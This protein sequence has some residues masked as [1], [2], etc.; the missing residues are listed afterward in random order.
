MFSFLTKK[1]TRSGL[2]VLIQKYATQEL[3][4]DIGSAKS[5]YKHW[6]PNRISVD[7]NPESG[8][9]IIADAHILP[10]ADESYECAL[11]TEMLEHMYDPK[12]AV[13]EMYRVLRPGGTLILT[14][15]F[16]YGLH[17]IPHD[18][19]RFTKYG[20]R[21]LFEKFEIIELKEETEN[22]AT[23]G[24]LIQRLVF[25]SDFKGGRFT[26]LLL[27]CIA[28]VFTRCN[29]LIV[30]QYGDIQKSKPEKSILASGYIIVCRKKLTYGSTN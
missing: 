11:S 12:K 20:L 9:N 26:K 5:P 14:T 2:D 16:V 7:I 28:R 17:D 21:K 24:A 3:T 6:F 4:L 15:R 30:R 13:D 8:A 29:G 23:I 1:I 19:F 27:L 10:V 18:F 25:Q 22:F